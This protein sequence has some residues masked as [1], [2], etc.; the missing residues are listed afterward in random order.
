MAHVEVSELLDLPVDEKVK[1]V[2]ALWDSIFA[3]QESLPISAA[4][5]LELERRLSAYDRDPDAGSPW[6]EVES[7]ITS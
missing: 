6:E 4:E 3:A 7:R 1:L 2:R 5:R